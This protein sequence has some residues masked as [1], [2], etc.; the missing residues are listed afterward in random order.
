MTVTGP[1][2][3]VDGFMKE[4]E[5]SAQARKGDGLAVFV[6]IPEQEI[7]YEGKVISTK[8]R[9]T[10][11]QFVL[12][13][14]EAG[15]ES[16]LLG[17][18]PEISPEPSP[19][20]SILIE[21]LELGARA[22]GALKRSGIKTLADLLARSQ[23]EIEGIRGFGKGAMKELRAD[24]DKRQ[25]KLRGEELKRSPGREFSEMLI[26]ELEVG[27]RLYNCLKRAGIHT[28]EELLQKDWSE[29]EA[30]PNLNKGKVSELKEA[31]R[32]RGWDLGMI[33]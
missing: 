29:I 1:L 5:R 32:A 17:P 15:Q 11:R 14:E 28:M 3:Q 23:F 8:I 33:D 12:G 2:D 6:T 9:L 7:P 18:Q 24:L 31:L 30:I 25:L 4:M 20:E 27:V 16:D 13:G 26:E 10:G 19:Y 21:E 22:Y